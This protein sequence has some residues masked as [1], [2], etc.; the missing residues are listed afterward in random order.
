MSEKD[1]QTDS[2]EEES[3]GRLGRIRKGRKKKRED[4]I[5]KV[6]EQL[7]SIQACKDAALTGDD[8]LRLLAVCRLGEYGAEAFDALDIALCD[9]SPVVRTVAAG[10]LA[11][12]EDKDAI[13]I[14]KSYLSD[15]DESVRDAVEYSL[16]W[17]DDRAIEKTHR[18]PIPK[19]QENPAQML[20][21]TESIPMKTSDDVEIVSTFSVIPES[22][23]FGMMVQNVG[24]VTI[25]DVSVKVLLYPYESLE[26]AEDLSQTIESIEPEGIEAII[27]GFSIV[28][29]CV[30]G[31]F[32][33]AVQ[34]V[35]GNG[36]N[37]AAKSGN[38][39]VRSLFE[40][41]SPLEITHEEFLSLKSELK[42]W[43]REHTLT[44]E[45]K[46]LF[47]IITDLYELWNLY[48]V[49][50]ESTEKDD[51]F[52]GV[53]SGM[54]EGRISGMKLAIT[55]TVV[56]KLNDDLSKLRIDALCEDSEI[57][58]TVASVLFE[59][60]QRRLGVIGTE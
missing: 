50:S 10:M 36:E 60:I 37:V 6:L 19:Q 51:T 34:F 23:E 38:I 54:A 44:T 13:E 48:N 56:G 24:E 3:V 2:S 45:A 33:T 32:V 20:L 31:E 47:R 58:H 53:I 30:E 35:D 25:R 52:M 28:K 59:I 16:N 18:T 41:F 26:P 43:N 14:L 40:Q 42:K 15:E 11:S 39:F 1:D 46:E 7:T 17:L 49:Q 12:S 27:F 29:E 55:L 21:E 22:L 4:N 9:D 5:G 57:L 8:N